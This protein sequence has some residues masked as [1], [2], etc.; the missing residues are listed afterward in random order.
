MKDIKN[1]MD[2][3][4]AHQEYPATKEDLV[5]T[6]NELSDFS[7]E[8]KKWFMDNLPER[9]YNSAEEVAEALGW[10]GQQPMAAM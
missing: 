10:S 2:H 1:A 9:T 4:K 5:K 8:D 3:L 6:C 7:E